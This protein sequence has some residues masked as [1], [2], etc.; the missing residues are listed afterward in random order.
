MVAEVLV[1]DIRFECSDGDSV[2]WQQ[3]LRLGLVVQGKPTLGD[4]WLP[5]WAECI[6]EVGSYE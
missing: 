6:S 5:M 4:F 2:V 3:F 1:Q